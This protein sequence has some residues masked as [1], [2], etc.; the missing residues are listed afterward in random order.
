MR[1]LDA[2]YRTSEMNIINVSRARCCRS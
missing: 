2:A 1:K